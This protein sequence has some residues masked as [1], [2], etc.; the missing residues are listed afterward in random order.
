MPLEKMSF[1]QRMVQLF[2]QE[3]VEA[4]F[5][6]GDLTMRDIQKHA[7]KA[8]LKIVGPR[9]EAAAVFMADAYYRMSGVPQVAIGAMGPGQ[10]N[11]LPA[12]I[13]AAQ[14]HIPV[15][16][17]GSR[18]QSVID[19]G[20]RRSRFL[21]APV[22]NCFDSI[23][24]F[25]AKITHP[26]ELDELVQEA[27]RKAL[28]GTPGP[29]YLE[30]DFVM[31]E[32][33]AEFLVP[34]KRPENYRVTKMPV[35]DEIIRQAVS[36][37]Q[38]ADCPVILGGTG[39]HTSLTHDPFERLCRLL[40]CPVF[41]TIGGSG[42]L[43]ETDNQWLHYFSESGQQ[44]IKECDLIVALGTSIP[45]TMNY[46]RQRH[47]SAGDDSRKWILIEQDPGAVGVN[48]SIDLA[49]VGK[50]ESALPQLCQALEDSQTE[51]K[52]PKLAQWRAQYEADRQ[53]SISALDG[54][55]T[56]NPSKLMTEARHAVP[57]NAITVV[58]SG[59]T[60]MQQLAFFEKRSPHFL[61]TSKY[62][63]LGSG[64]PYAIGAKLQA[65]DDKPVC[66]IS[67]DGGLGFHFMEFETAVRHQLPIVIIV[68][69]DEALGAEMQAH[70]DHIGH[71]IE[72]SFSSTR[73]DQMAVAMGGHGE[74]VDKEEDIQPAIRRAFDSGKP[75]IV[76][77]K[78]DPQSAIKYPVPYVEELMSWLM[79]D[80]SQSSANSMSIW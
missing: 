34:A 69:D 18:R 31:H 13:C 51:F 71:T 63:H 22:F 47:F 19:S 37:I 59:L 49:I 45:E 4:I 23:C 30:Y 48:H 77:V 6:Q 73:F 35:A 1:G 53:S 68:N 62:G 72:V 44:V 61:W 32:A 12:V 50:L 28:T 21:Y 42:T 64:L 54:A 70:M 66:L 79:E 41:T 36:L 25:A 10:A 3:G 38:A 5:S 14:E 60:V 2:Q 16:V 24:K 55:E 58:D 17:L 56:I 39:I 40:A 33:E 43:L 15:I 65:G 8:G 74:Y 29:V 26:G 7:E 76:Q 20:V 67:G 75:A 57:D 11:L 80:A 52:N 27:F 9:H 78:T 46:G